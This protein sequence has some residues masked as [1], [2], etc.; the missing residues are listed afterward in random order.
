MN[1]SPGTAV[2]STFRLVIEAI[3]SQLIIRPTEEICYGDN[4]R[5]VYR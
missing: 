3:F 4:Q 2:I 1:T 5:P